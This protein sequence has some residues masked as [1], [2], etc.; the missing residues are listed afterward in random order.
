M[1]YIKGVYGCS[2]KEP[3]SATHTRQ[4]YLCGHTTVT[5]HY[6][7]TL[8]FFFR[9]SN[10][11]R[12]AGNVHS[13]ILF[14]QV[15]NIVANFFTSLPIKDCTLH[16]FLYTPFLPFHLTKPTIILSSVVTRQLAKA[17]RPRGH[18]HADYFYHTKDS[19]L[20]YTFFPLKI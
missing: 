15:L 18:A 19:L 2:F 4:H 8:Y 13:T 11:S 14:R 10:P 12:L 17:A 7:T 20:C 16:L 5:S 1:G 9:T 3:S 6:M